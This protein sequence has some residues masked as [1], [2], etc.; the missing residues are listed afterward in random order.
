MLSAQNQEMPDDTAPE[1]SAT[2]TGTGF[3]K[4]LSS[5][6]GL[7]QRLDDFSVEEVSRAHAKAHD[8]IS[9]LGELQAQLNAL[10][11]LKE[12]IAGVNAEMRAIPEDNYDLVGPNSLEKH[13]QLRAIVQASKL[14]RM[15]RLLSAARASA[16]SVSFDFQTN[17]SES[18]PSSSITSPILLRRIP[19]RSEEPGVAPVGGDVGMS[20][21][22]ASTE[23]ATEEREKQLSPFISSPVT[24]EPQAALTYEFADL[25]LDEAQAIASSCERGSPPSA[26]PGQEHAARAQDSK[27]AGKPNFDQRLLNDLI[28]TYGEFA[29]STSPVLWSK[30]VETTLPVAEESL[31]GPARAP[32]V[33]L[34]T[35]TPASIASA[36]TELMVPELASV[37]IARTEPAFVQPMTGGPRALP[38][39][40][41]KITRPAFENALPSAKSRG[42]IDRQLKNIIKD[43]GEY[44]LYSHQKSISNKT[45][46]VVIAAVA[47]LAMVL[48]GLYFFRT[49]SSPAPAAIETLVPSG[50]NRR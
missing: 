50:D 37:E 41:Q 49:P 7:Q 1:S 20:A 14:I 46:T 38:A 29:L 11:K 47:A 23:I 30:T 34:S 35:N 9:Q 43:Y 2:P 16:E 26:E 44:D 39:P 19:P 32:R 48:G 8:L 24:Q 3:G 17:Q 12:A 36:G 15:H 25:K 10:A 18:E 42:E 22:P 6:Q 13:P 31:S 4:V 40:R 33:D 5:I 45:K 28:E 21:S 27:S